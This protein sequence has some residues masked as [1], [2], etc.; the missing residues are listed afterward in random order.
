MD[1]IGRR[2]FEA[3]SGKKQL[4]KLVSSIYLGGGLPFAT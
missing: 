1:D 2:G 4:L 3:N